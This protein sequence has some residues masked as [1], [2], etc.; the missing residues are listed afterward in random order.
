[1]PIRLANFSDEPV[2]LKAGVLVSELVETMPS[3]ETP[4]QESWRE[5]ARVTAQEASEEL[6]TALARLPEHLHNL[7]VRVADDLRR[8]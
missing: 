1:M 4:K 3:Q 5:V 8:L 6:E 2:C 7:F